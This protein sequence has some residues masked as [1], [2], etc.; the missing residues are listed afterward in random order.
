MFLPRLLACAAVGLV[1]LS[2]GHGFAQPTKPPATTDSP[3]LPTEKEAMKVKREHAHAALDAL[4]AGD[5]AAVK[6]NAEV[7]LAIAEMRV[8]LAG[9][10]TDE[11][12]FQ[13]KAFKHAARDLMTAAEAKNIDG[14][15]LAYSDMTR[16]CVK[17]HTHFRGVGPKKD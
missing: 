1:A 12:Q 13:A 10:K 4:T 7:L 3:P 9:Y 6:R 11:Y 17:C 15:A 14:A 2:V 16:T 8:F 5:H